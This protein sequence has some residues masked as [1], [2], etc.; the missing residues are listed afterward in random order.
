MGWEAKAAASRGYAGLL[1]WTRAPCGRTQGAQPTPPTF[2]R[3]LFLLLAMPVW[4]RVS[5]TGP[6]GCLAQDT[7][8]PLASEHQLAFHVHPQPTTQT[9]THTPQRT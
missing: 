2:L 1:F 7:L 8:L 4:R 6:F 5:W 3:A 9:H